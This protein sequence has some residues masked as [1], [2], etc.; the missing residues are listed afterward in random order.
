[1]NLVK[2]KKMFFGKESGVF[3]HRTRHAAHVKFGI[4][5]L[6]KRGE[7]LEQRKEENIVKVL[8]EKN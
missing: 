3:C 1:M 4:R 8:E 2:L 6:L 7:S 5:G